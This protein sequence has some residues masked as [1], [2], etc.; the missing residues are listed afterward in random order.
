MLFQKLKNFNNNLY[1]QKLVQSFNNNRRGHY[2]LKIFMWLLLIV[3]LAEFIANDKPLLLYFNGKAYFPT[4]ETISEEELGGDYV[5]EPDYADPYMQNIISNHGF[6]IMPLIHFNNNTINKSLPTPAPSSPTLTNWLG[7]DDQGRDIL[8]RLIYGLRLSI[9]FST[10][11]TISSISIG[12]FLGAIQGYFGGKLDIFLQ[13]FIEVWSELPFLYILI[14]LFSII[15]PNFWWLLLV[16]L[17]FSWVALVG[18]VRAEFLKARNLEYVMAAKVLGVSELKIIFKHILPNAMVASFTFLP[19]IFN[20][21]LTTL[22]ALD[23]LGLGLPPGSPSLGEML[24]QAKNNLTAY[25]IGTSIF[26]TLTILL[27][28]LIFIGEA[29]NDAFDPRR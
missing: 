5:N 13:R 26:F 8:A 14:I 4:F 27:A 10:L 2:S 25:W 21:S 22:T 7:T 24:F 16:L 12:I 18:M 15:T 9:I 19:F 23:F 3:S 20:S 6:M 29:I 11:L 28:L 17:L 1:I